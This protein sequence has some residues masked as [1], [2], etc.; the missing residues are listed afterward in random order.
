M[1]GSGRRHDR[2]PVHEPA[3]IVTDGEMR[4][5]V[6][7]DVSESGAA[8]EFNLEKNDTICLDIGHGVGVKS[9]S[10]QDRPARIIRHYDSGFAINFDDYDTDKTN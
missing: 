7:V 4:D 10:L 9:E 3:S 8:I 6:V 5:G 1:P 2:K